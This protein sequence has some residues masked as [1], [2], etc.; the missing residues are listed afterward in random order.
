[1]GFIT[2]VSY[3]WGVT[4]TSGRGLAATIGWDSCSRL[5][6]GPRCSPAGKGRRPPGVFW[7]GREAGPGRLQASV[8]PVCLRNGG[9][10]LNRHRQWR[11]SEEVSP[12]SCRNVG[13]GQRASD[14]PLYDVPG[15]QIGPCGMVAN[16]SYL[17]TSSLTAATG[18]LVRGPAAGPRLARAAG[19]MTTVESLTAGGRRRHGPRR[20]LQGGRRRW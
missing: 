12:G 3:M 9:S 8:C 17:R 6:G 20:A 4:R 1:M 14:Q 15:R 5:A 7:S 16:D 2:T 11:I 13:P 10:S 18:S 19:W